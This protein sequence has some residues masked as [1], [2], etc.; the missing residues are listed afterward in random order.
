[1]QIV[2]DVA[3]ADDENALLPEGRKALA[4]FV[5]ERGWL[6]LVDAELHYRNIGVRIHMAQH[7]PRAV[8]ESP[9]FIESHRQGSKQ[10]LH[11]GKRG[12]GHRAL[13]TELGTVLAGTRRS[14]ELSL[15][16]C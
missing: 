4:D 3:A 13:D 10:L 6:S 11:T 12:L 9:A 5:V 8:V 15:G 1:M 16:R 2:H 14:R 7:R